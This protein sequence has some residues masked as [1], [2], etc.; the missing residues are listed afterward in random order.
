MGH[1]LYGFG[2]DQVLHVEMVLPNGSHIRF[3]PSS[4]EW[5]G[6]NIYPQ[7]R[8][9]SGYCNKNP[10]TDEADWM[11]E[12]CDEEVPFV[13][14]WFATRGG[15]GGQFGVVTAIYYQLHDKPGVYQD[16]PW[17]T[18][19][20]EAMANPPNGVSVEDILRTWYLYLFTFL[21]RPEDIGI[22]KAVSNSCSAP[23]F[24]SLVSGATSELRAH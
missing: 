2:I 9:V 20:R 19:L 22:D 24:P 5:E 14:L 1:R 8:T 3:G 13:D 12:E 15:G 16:V 17:G 10:Q 11:W 18:P 7:T 4:W 6:D 21:Y 23:D